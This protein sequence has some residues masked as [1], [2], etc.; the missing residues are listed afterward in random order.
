MTELAFEKKIRPLVYGFDCEFWHNKTWNNASVFL[1]P[2]AHSLMNVYDKKKLT[3][4]KRWDLYEIQKL[5]LKSFLTCK[6]NDYNKVVKKEMSV[7]GLFEVEMRDH[8]I[9]FFYIENQKLKNSV[10]DAIKAVNNLVPDNEICRYGVEAMSRYYMN[11]YNDNQ[12]TKAG[13][14]YESVVNF[15]MA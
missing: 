10:C 7:T 11:N 3:L 13:N 4:L 12:I 2:E 6:A 9:N 8:D 14:T 15:F 1:D 5:E